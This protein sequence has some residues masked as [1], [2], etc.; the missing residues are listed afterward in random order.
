MPAA[1]GGTEL[2]SPEQVQELQ[3]LMSKVKNAQSSLVTQKLMKRNETNLMQK[4]LVN[5]LFGL[6]QQAGVDPANPESVNAFLAK[7]GQQSPDLLEL[8]QQA[9]TDLTGGPLGGMMPQP[10]EPMP[11]AGG[12]TPSGTLMDQFRSLPG[13]MPQS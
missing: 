11:T 6:L 4:R 8:F 3:D 13:A 10:P 12:G 1:P 5:N 9:F 7:L 2:A